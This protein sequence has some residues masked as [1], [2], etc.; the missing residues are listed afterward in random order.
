MFV[1]VS[2]IVINMIVRTVRCNNMLLY[3]HVHVR[4]RCLIKGLKN[5]GVVYNTE[6]SVTVY[7][8]SDVDCKCQDLRTYLLNDISQ[9]SGSL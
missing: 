6:V 9:G 1:Y 5:D 3:C 4:L 2:M 8:D 7:S